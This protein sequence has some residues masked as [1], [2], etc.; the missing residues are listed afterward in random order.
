MN[1]QSA[2]QFATV[3]RVHVAIAVRD[4]E[5]SIP[6]YSTL[7]G[8]PPTK[9]RPGY[10]KFE[11]AEPPVNLA[12][13]AA[14]GPTGPHDAVSHFGVQVKSADAV[15]EVAARLEAAGLPT[16]PE[17]NVTCC[18]AVQDKV[19]VAD[20]DG[21]RWEVFVVLD[22]AGASYAP[23][24]NAAC[25]PQMGPA[26]ETARRGDFEAAASGYDGA[27]GGRDCCPPDCCTSPESASGTAAATGCCTP[28]A[29]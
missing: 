12:L 20:P 5:K 23:V 6:F 9:T 2:V 1:R 7:F 17:E 21:H 14:A 28:A 26:T 22:D 15:R 18:H 19:W 25:R 16:R 24:P 13:N 4:V 10:A 3:S 8:Q 27:S 29:V 11:V